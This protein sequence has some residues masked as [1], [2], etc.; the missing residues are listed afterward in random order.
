MS[1][2]STILSSQKL[3]NLFTCSTFMSKIYDTVITCMSIY[4]FEGWYDS[5]SIIWPYNLVLGLTYF[6]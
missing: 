5:F 4:V 3:D 1:L 2:L 6:I